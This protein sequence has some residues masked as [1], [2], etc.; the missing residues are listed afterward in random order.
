MGVFQVEALSGQV[1]LERSFLPPPIPY[2]AGLF[3]GLCGVRLR[4]DA[5]PERL[6][7]ALRSVRSPLCE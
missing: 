4:R 7:D 5:V 6:G 3:V 2:R 1:S